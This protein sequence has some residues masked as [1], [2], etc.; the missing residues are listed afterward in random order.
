LG[1]ANGRQNQKQVR[2]NADLHRRLSGLILFLLKLMKRTREEAANTIEAFIS[3]TGRQ[4][5]WDGFTSIRLDDPELEA[6]RQRCVVLPAEF[7]PTTRGAYCSD[8]GLQVMRDLV[9]GLRSQP[10]GRS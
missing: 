6:I 8:A 10:A 9:K 1:Q 3:G 5:D 2:F 4:W 7:P